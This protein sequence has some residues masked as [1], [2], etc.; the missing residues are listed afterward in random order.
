MVH[1]LVIFHIL[2]SFISLKPLVSKVQE[3]RLTAVL[4]LYYDLRW[5]VVNKCD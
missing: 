3:T 2:L 4:V 5:G 1:F